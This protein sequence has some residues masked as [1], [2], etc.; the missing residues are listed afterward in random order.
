MKIGKK[1]QSRAKRI[2]Q[3]VLGR[4]GT[5]DAAFSLWDRA[6]EVLEGF[7]FNRTAR[8]LSLDLT[9]SMT[10]KLDVFRSVVESALGGS[11][12]EG[13][14]TLVGGIV[15]EDLWNAIPVIREGV[16]KSF[17]ARTGQVDV[18]IVS[19]E[20][21]SEQERQKVVQ[22][23]SGSMGNRR[24]KADWKTEPALIAGLVIQSGTHVW[25]GSLKGRLNQLKQE[26]LDWA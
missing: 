23:L 26:L 3:Y 1:A 4:I 14:D 2:V 9:V 16:R 6:T 13:F 11:V 20:S 25:D 21:L 15:L 18:T 19:A 10:R 12:P 5:D 24:V 7:R 17:Y 22:T 8:T